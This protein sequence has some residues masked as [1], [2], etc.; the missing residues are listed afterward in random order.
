MKS[1]IV[2]KVKEVDPCL[3]FSQPLFIQ[4]YIIIPSL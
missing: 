1:S 3:N 2:L 4:D